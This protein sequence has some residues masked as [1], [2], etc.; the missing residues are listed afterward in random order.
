MSLCIYL[1]CILVK[2][3][4]SHRESYIS[5]HQGGKKYKKD[6]FIINTKEARTGQIP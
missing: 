1:L 6:K 2:K 5:L 3:L 4:L